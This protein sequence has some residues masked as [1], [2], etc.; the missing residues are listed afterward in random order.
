MTE[1]I[2]LYKSFSQKIWNIKRTKWISMNLKNTS[3]SGDINVMFQVKMTTHSNTCTGWTA[4]NVIEFVV[5]CYSYYIMN[6][7][8]IYFINSSISISRKSITWLI[9]EILLFFNITTFTSSLIRTHI[10]ENKCLKKKIN[11]H[12]LYLIRF[13]RYIQ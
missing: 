2:L 7:N 13:V 10:S 11:I 9:L 12:W 5:N 4:I 1:D 6:V 3:S 8:F